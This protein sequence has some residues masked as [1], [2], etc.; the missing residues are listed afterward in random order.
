MNIIL[1]KEITPVKSW[2]YRGKY[3]ITFE[4]EVLETKGRSH[5]TPR[6]LRV[7]DCI[8]GVNVYQDELQYIEANKQEEAQPIKQIEIKTIDPN[9]ELID[10]L[11][12]YKQLLEDEKSKN[13]LLE[14]ELSFIKARLGN[15]LQ[16][17]NLANINELFK[18]QGGQDSTELRKKMLEQIVKENVNLRNV[19]KEI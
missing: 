10:Q 6:V 9:K 1:K 19:I 7:I 8:R 2:I 5:L 12:K 13:R 17:L 11:N 14:G 15:D 3:K 16:G 4:R 18:Q